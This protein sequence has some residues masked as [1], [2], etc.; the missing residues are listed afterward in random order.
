LGKGGG[1]EH[2]ADKEKIV[3]GCEGLNAKKKYIPRS[4]V[5]RKFN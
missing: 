4:R 5:E 3:G 2:H 1:V